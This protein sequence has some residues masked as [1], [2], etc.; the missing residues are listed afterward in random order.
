MLFY[1]IYHYVKYGEKYLVFL[2]EFKNIKEPLTVL[3]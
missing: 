1:D 3:R 2:I